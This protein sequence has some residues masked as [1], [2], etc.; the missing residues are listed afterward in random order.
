MA[1]S[2]KKQFQLTLLIVTSLLLTACATT[3]NKQVLNNV[4]TI[5]IVNYLPKTPY[6][7]T[8]GTTLINTEFDKINDPQFYQLINDTFVKHIE[9]RGYKVAILEKND[10][11][12]FDLIIKLNP[13][14]FETNPSMVSYG[15]HHDSLLG[16]PLRTF[17][18]MAIDYQTCLKEEFMC[19]AEQV[20]AR[21]KIDIRVLPIEYEDLSPE[22][23]TYAAQKLNDVI[24]AA[25]TK[26]LIQSGI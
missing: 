20:D 4:K 15:L 8:S 14:S 11:E 3:L 18:Y 21:T 6:M 17:A 2:F 10:K 26:L 7:I 1:L 5:G 25:V 9:S 19:V 16:M 22:E 24:E 13:G 12:N 23:K